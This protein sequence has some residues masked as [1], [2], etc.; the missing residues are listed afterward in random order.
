MLSRQNQ[1]TTIA[2]AY[3][4]YSPDSRID[5]RITGLESQWMHTQRDIETLN[6]AILGLGR[7]LDVL[8]KQFSQLIVRLDILQFRS[9]ASPPD[10]KPPHY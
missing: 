9:E 7:Q 10:E 1:K 2:E 4:S 5:S 6:E 8:Q 3:S